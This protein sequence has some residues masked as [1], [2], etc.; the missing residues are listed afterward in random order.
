MRVQVHGSFVEQIPNDAKQT[1]L[2]VVGAS[3][4]NVQPPRSDFG[5]HEYEGK[6]GDSK[7]D[8]VLRCSFNAWIA[9]L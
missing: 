1:L 6:S 2:C 3:L 5:G 8:V 4:V 9:R 7:R